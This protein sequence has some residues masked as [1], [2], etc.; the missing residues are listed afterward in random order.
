MLVREPDEI[1]YTNTYK[2]GPIWIFVTWAKKEGQA[3]ANVDKDYRKRSCIG[4]HWRQKLVET[5]GEGYYVG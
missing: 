3:E 5:I 2:P 1:W 4:R